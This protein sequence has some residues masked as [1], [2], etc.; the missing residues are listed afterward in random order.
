ML[1]IVFCV[2]SGGLVRAGSTSA[3]AV[4]SILPQLDAIY[5]RYDW[6]LNDML[7]VYFC[8]LFQEWRAKSSHIPLHKSIM[9]LRKPTFMLSIFLAIHRANC[10]GMLLVVRAIGGGGPKVS[11]YSSV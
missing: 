10:H 11:L 8:P 4:V 3:P 6:V 7:H 2:T 5:S 1:S 9:L